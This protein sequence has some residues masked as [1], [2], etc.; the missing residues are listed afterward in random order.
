MKS[1]NGWPSF[2]PGLFSWLDPPPQLNVLRIIKNYKPVRVTCVVVM[3]TNGRF[4]KEGFKV[5]Q[6]LVEE[7]KSTQTFDENFF[8]ICSFF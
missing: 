2:P 7:L 5:W 3:G 1:L 4:R 8:D 6:N